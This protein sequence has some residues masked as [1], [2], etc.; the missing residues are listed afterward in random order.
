VSAGVAG[1]SAAKLKIMEPG[2]RGKSD[3]D[4]V[5]ALLGIAD[6][7]FQDALLRQAQ[8]AGKLERGY[9]IPDAARA[10]LPQRLADALAPL[11]ARGLFP[12]F[13]FGSDFTE[14]ELRLIPALQHLKARSATKLGALGL[15]L[16][17]LLPGTSTKELEPLLQRMGFERPGSLKERFYQRLLT[18][19][20]R[21]TQ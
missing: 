20:L 2:V 4:A 14:E 8:R 19:G 15:A 9:R 18:V 16:E 13:P 1:V 12:E 11:R 10:N 5:K 21:K 7:R 17:G 6:A 3:E